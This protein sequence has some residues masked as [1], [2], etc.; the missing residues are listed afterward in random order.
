VEFVVEN[1][2][3]LMESGEGEADLPLVLEN[4]TFRLSRKNGS[5]IVRRTVVILEERKNPL[6]CS[7]L[8]RDLCLPFYIVVCP[9]S[10][11]D[12]SSVLR[13]IGIM[14]VDFIR[15]PPNRSL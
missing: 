10:D 14:H 7:D 13:I 15:N 5:G 9:L 6:Y 2:G 8:F 4:R 1:I 12:I 11:T 3:L